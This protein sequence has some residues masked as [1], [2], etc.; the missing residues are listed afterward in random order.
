MHNV[1]QVVC[2]ALLLVFVSS[3]LLLTADAKIKTYCGSIPLQSTDWN[4]SVILPKF[5]VQEGTLNEVNI[6]CE[7][8]LSE[9]VYVENLNK[10]PINY[11][12]NISGAFLLDLPG[13]EDLSIP[14]SH[15]SGG[16]QGS[17]DGNKDYSGQSGTNI[18][19]IIP[20]EHAE[21]RITVVDDFIAD[22]HGENI[23]LPAS[24]FVYSHLDAP[25]STSLGVD[26][27]VGV[28]VCISYS[29]D[30]AVKTDGVS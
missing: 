3:L 7:L 26:T 2:I 14:F 24:V 11:T 18:S 21:K 10:K 4:A 17:S 25:S 8:N 29:Y 19:S 16:S 5:D 30:P 15:N 6:S 12:A 28:D 13:S 23:T 1:K 22:A 20:P 27:E 9:S